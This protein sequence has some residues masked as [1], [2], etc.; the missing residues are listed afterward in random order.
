MRIDAP[1]D[2][3]VSLLCGRQNG[4]G[5]HTSSGYVKEAATV[6]KEVL[7]SLAGD[8]TSMWEV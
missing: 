7:A 1:N 4:P 5:A 8:G 3:P 2:D 6:Q